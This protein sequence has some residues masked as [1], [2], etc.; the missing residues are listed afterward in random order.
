MLWAVQQ[1]Y[2]LQKDGPGFRIQPNKDTMRLGVAMPPVVCDVND[3]IY[4]TG[5]VSIS[6]IIILIGLPLIYISESISVLGVMYGV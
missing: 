6:S 5:S 3:G 1:P 2:C 4:S